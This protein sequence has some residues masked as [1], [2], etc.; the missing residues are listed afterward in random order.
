MRLFSTR[1]RKV[2]LAATVLATS[3][4]II[5]N[6]ATSA[7]AAVS[8]TNG[9]ITVTQS[10]GTTPMNSGGSQTQYYVN[11]SNSPGKPAA[12]CSAD[13]ASGST[14]VYSYA[15][16]Q[17]V[18]PTTLSFASGHPAG[19]GAAYGSTAF[20]MFQSPNG[21]YYGG[22]TTAV[23][24]GQVQTNGVAFQWNPPLGSTHTS[25]VLYNGGA[26]SA[27]NVGLACWNSATSAITDYWNVVITFSPDSTDTG[28]YT[29]TAANNPQQSV[30]E[31]PL[32]IVLPL[33]AVALIGGGVMFARRRRPNNGTA[34]A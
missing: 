20:G 32:P 1:F 34:A 31:V 7:Y 28:G 18:D 16:H 24:T 14:F 27:W 33:A 19:T 21:T 23:S 17:S 12:D 22:Q 2:G 4:G 6:G 11:L 29:W 26:A 25:Q 8:G 9:T 5:A 30:P 10:D 13:S 15:V 3:G